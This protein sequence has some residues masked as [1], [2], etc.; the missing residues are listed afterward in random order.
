[1]VINFKK[2]KDS[3]IKFKKP[4]EKKIV[5]KV[6]KS[7]NPEAETSPKESKEESN[8]D[9]LEGSGLFT[10]QILIYIIIGI[11]SILFFVIIY[12]LFCKAKKPIP[13]DSHTEESNSISD[14]NSSSN[15]L[16]IK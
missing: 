11:I 14:M 5:K 2:V 13:E 10:I 8:I 12:I 3:L 6:E 1:M 15:G 16:E 4:K 7:S 9:D